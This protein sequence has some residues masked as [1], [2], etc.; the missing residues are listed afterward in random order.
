MQRQRRGIVWRDCQSAS[1]EARRIAGRASVF[2]QRG[3]S[4]PRILQIGVCCRRRLIAFRRAIRIALGLRHDRAMQR[5]L[6]GLTKPLVQRRQCGMNGHVVRVPLEDVQI[7][8]QRLLLA[9]LRR[10]TFGKARS[11]RDKIRCQVHGVAIRGF[12]GVELLQCRQ[13]V[14]AQH[15]GIAVRSIRRDR[16]L[17]ARQR[18]IHLAKMQQAVSRD[19]QRAGGLR[20]QPQHVIGGSERRGIVQPGNLGCRQ[21]QP[22]HR[23][24]GRAC[25]RFAVGIDR[26]LRMAAQ[27]LG[28]A[29]DVVR[30]GRIR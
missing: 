17:A 4:E 14:A 29:D 1:D 15:A 21:M 3:T 8:A 27:A 23:A 11:E 13:R 12:G 28:A 25:T 19:Q 18:L 30:L 10:E 2:R 20:R 5:G 6:R 26:R 16:L 9:S 24:A 22:R 7:D